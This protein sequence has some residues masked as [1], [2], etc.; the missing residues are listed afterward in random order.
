MVLTDDNFATLVSAVHQGRKLY[1]NILKFVRFQLSTTIGA[2]LTVFFAPL[3]GLP[4][5]FSAIQIL[6]VALIMDGPPAVSLALDAARPGIMHEPPRMRDEPIL[7][8]FRLVK[9][10]SFGITM[11]VGTLAVLY[12][13]W[14]AG[15]G[16]RAVTLGFTT[17]VLFQVFNV[18][19]ARVEHGS[20]FNRHFFDNPMLWASL[21][22]VVV[23]Q[24]IAVHWQPAQKI[25]GTFPM[26]LGDWGIAVSVAASILVLEE[27]RKLLGRVS[28]RLFRR[29]DADC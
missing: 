16:E 26:T 29:P 5:P 10:I 3:L 6:W 24:A 4:E 8:L 21:G 13:G 19:N 22:G 18:F 1:D 14:H 23:L 7:P 27:S 11:M 28:E 20:A 12:Y 25:V 2:I 9:I 15:M 17:F